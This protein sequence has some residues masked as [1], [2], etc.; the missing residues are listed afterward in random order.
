MTIS[1]EVHEADPCSD[2]QTGFSWENTS[3]TDVRINMDSLNQGCLCA[4]VTC[5]RHTESLL[6]QIITNT[7]SFK[8]YQRVG[9][10]GILFKFVFHTIHCGHPSFLPTR[11]CTLS[12]LS[13]SP[14]ISLCPC[15]SV[16]H[17]KYKNQISDLK[18]K[19]IQ[20]LRRER[21]VLNTYIASAG[22]WE[23][24]SG[25]GGAHL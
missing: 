18:R 10:S 22:A 4:G 21:S 19:V 6:A 23:P 16:S 13:L 3:L 15:L 11:L 5:K 9:I 8:N 24:S 14:L 12:P 25:N 17:T 20:E 1:E 7:R 2:R